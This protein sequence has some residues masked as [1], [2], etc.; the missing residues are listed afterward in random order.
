MKTL[1]IAI[2]L[3]ISLGLGFNSLTA[4][5]STQQVQI[6]DDDHAGW[7]YIRVFEDGAIWV[8][9]MDEDGIFVTKYLEQQN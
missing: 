3:T 6:S 1:V 2:A 9:V 5:S 7:T 4:E 8:Y